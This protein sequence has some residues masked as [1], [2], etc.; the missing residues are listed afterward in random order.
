[1]PGRPEYSRQAVQ[2]WPVI[3]DTAREGGLGGALRG[4]ET[5]GQTVDTRQQMR[6]LLPAAAL[7]ILA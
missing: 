1:M 7:R 2:T 4:P 5:E 6:A 3:E